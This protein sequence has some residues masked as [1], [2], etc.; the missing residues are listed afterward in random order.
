MNDGEEDC[1]FFRGFAADVGTIAEYQSKGVCCLMPGTTS[2]NC[3]WFLCACQFAQ[4][5]Q[6]E[7]IGKI[8]RGKTVAEQ[9][10]KC[11]ATRPSPRG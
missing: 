3:I 10:R 2:L 6:L 7:R 11:T 1:V 8:C 9:F 4:A 5:G